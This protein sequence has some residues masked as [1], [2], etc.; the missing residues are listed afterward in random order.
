MYKL[1]QRAP[2]IKHDSC[3]A[4]RFQHHGLE[5]KQA[6]VART[7]GFAGVELVETEGLTLFGPTKEPENGG[8]EHM[9]GCTADFRIVQGIISHEGTLPESDVH[10][11][12]CSQT[13]PEE[14]LIEDF[15]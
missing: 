11:F 6:G 3:L 12:M 1:I 9:N 4:T 15:A 7:R 14:D 2:M 8:S 10:P 13:P 5:M